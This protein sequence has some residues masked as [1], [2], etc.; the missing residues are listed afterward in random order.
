MHYDETI[1][2]PPLEANT[3]LLQV[4]SGCSHNNCTYC[5][6]YKDIKFEMTSLAQIEE[7]LKELITL[8]TTIKRIYLLNGDPFSLSAERLKTIA[9]LIKKYL[10]KCKTI[11]MYASIK[12]IK[13]KTIEE[14]RELKSLGIG[15]LYIGLESGN[16][17]VL[18]N[19]NKG[20]TAKETKAQMQRLNEVGIRFFSIIMYG[21]AGKDKGIA[22]AIDTA[23]LLNEV[24]S[25]GI[26]PMSLTLVPGT[27]LHND[28]LSGDFKEA[29]ELERLIE[30]KTLIENLS[31]ENSTV[32]SAQHPSNTVPLSGIMPRN[33]Q[34]LIATLNKVI[35]NTDEESLKSKFARN[36]IKM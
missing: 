11:S 10:P 20:T 8:N 30:L 23:K 29:S 21:V 1:Y 33:K 26:F 9:L 34:D 32:F 12:G 35:E 7:D 17:E 16:D 19:I 15:D 24:K 6:M 36:K 3:I 13:T 27:K 22:N 4:T 25:K 28:Y 31:L 2:R 5:G 14:L 18:K